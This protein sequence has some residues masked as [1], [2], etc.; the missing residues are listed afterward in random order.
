MKSSVGLWVDHKTAVMVSLQDEVVTV[1]EVI[2]GVER[3]IRLAGGSRS[4]TP[5][6][7]QD[8]V[9]EGKHHR[10]HEA[11]LRDFYEKLACRVDD[12][13][14]I[15]IMGPGEAK[16]ELKKAIEK[17]KH[18][19]TRIVGVEVADKMTKNQIVAKVRERLGR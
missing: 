11:Q 6:G 4:S 5:F 10:R 15:L 16:R 17:R 2:S 3:Y 12:A 18:L 14:R 1:E 9:S 19:R 7:A 13:A 8:V